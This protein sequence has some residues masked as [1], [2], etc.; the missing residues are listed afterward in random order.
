MLLGCAVHENPQLAAY[1]PAPN[2]RVL[3]PIPSTA[4][5]PAH[6]VVPAPDG[7]VTSLASI[8]RSF[9]GVVGIAITSVDSGWIASANYLGYLS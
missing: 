8:T 9:N 3:L 7:L 5:A 1:L 6:P 2:Y 4:A